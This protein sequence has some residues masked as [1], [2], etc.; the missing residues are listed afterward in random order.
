[1]NNFVGITEQHV[2]ADSDVPCGDKLILS[3][4]FEKQGEEPPGVAF[5][6]LSLYVNER[7]VGSGSIKLQPGAYGLDAFL[8]VGR[9]L[10]AS[11]TGD[12]HAP[13][14]F[15]GGAIKRLGVDVSGEPYLNLEREA[16]AM[17]R[18]S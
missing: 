16:E 6:T 12:Y 4:S 11:V 14:P 3:A 13:F 5:G 15:T 9:A 17:L 8:T 1:M 10:G 18:R 2:D 7:K